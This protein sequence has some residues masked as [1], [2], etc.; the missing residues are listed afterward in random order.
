MGVLGK[1]TLARKVFDNHGTK[2]H[3]HCCIWVTVSESYNMEELL[4]EIKKQYYKVMGKTAPEEINNFNLISLVGKLREC[5]QNKRCVV[6]FNDFWGT[7]KHAFTDNNE[8]SRII[9]TTRNYN[10][11]SSCKEFSIVHIHEIQTLTPE[12]A[13]ELFCKRAFKYSIIEGCQP[14]LEQLSA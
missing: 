10:V 4:K 8:G 3:F 12:K 9:A 11:A 5:L 6:I 1:T 14:K 13:M 2:E 7:I